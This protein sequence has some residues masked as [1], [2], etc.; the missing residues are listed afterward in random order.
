MPINKDVSTDGIRRQEERFSV[1][2]FYRGDA[3]RD[4]IVDLLGKV[5]REAIEVYNG[6]IE[7]VADAGTLKALRERGLTVVVENERSGAFVVGNQ[8][9]TPVAQAEIVRPAPMNL[10]VDKL[11]LPSPE[12]GST[13][14]RRSQ[15]KPPAGEGH[16]KKLEQLRDSA[17]VF[18]E[19]RDADAEAS[20]SFSADLQSAEPTKVYNVF[21]SIPVRPR[22]QA[23]LQKIGSGVCSY[24]A[25]NIY[26]MFLSAGEL[27][28]VKELPF[29]TGVRDY[30]I[31]ESV[32][33]DF[34]NVISLAKPKT[35]DGSL[36]SFELKAPDTFD[37]LLHRRQDRDRVIRAIEKAG[38]KVVE[39]GSDILRFTMQS[40]A[41]ALGALA[42]LPEVRKITPW[43]PPKLFADHARSVIGIEAINA[44]IGGQA[45][46]QYTGKDEI[47]GIFDS[48]IDDTH[49]DFAGQVKEK[50]SHN[51]C[52]VVDTIGHGTHVAGIVAGTGVASSGKIRGIAPGAKLVVVGMVGADKHLNIPPDIGELLVKAVD[53]GAK[54]INLSWG[55]KF[56]SAYEFGSLHLDRFVYDHQDV[57]VVVAA[58]NSG[59]VEDGRYVLYSIGTPATAKNALTVGASGNDRADIPNLWSYPPFSFP[60]PAGDLRMANADHVGALSSRGPTDYD[61]VKPDVCACGIYVLSARAGQ[62][63]MPFLEPDYTAYNNS[64]AFL[65]GTSMAAPV[66]SGAAAVLREYLRVAEKVANPSAALLKALLIASAHRLEQFTKDTGDPFMDVVGFPDFHQGF[67]R[68]DLASII[69]HPKAPAKRR[70][71]MDDVYNGTDRALHS[72]AEVGSKHVAARSYQLTVSANATDPLR[73]V[74]AWTDVPGKFLHNNLQLYVEGAG[75]VR[76]GNADLKFH[77]D[78]FAGDALARGNAPAVVKF[79]EVPFDKYNNVEQL[80]IEKPAAGDYRI[81]ILAQYTDP[82]SCAQGYALCV[83]GELDSVKLVEV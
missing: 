36:L 45:S 62:A 28:Q 41:G 71:L 30:G 16:E 56:G 9:G 66:V 70:I 47:V 38:G 21:V 26:R 22:Y 25:P 68:I 63:T 34:L 83:C 23:A 77:R 50:V 49:P 79:G 12:S 31:E 54:V 7:G 14:S 24:E 46:V 80:T 58:G 8:I 73:A 13:M 61:S 35:G 76:V 74:L 39:S 51:G 57:L 5:D 37:L 29:V 72:A 64:Y 27:E 43:R 2:V 18:R 55:D 3:Q 44:D 60:A 11:N 75:K 78:P 53:L 82:E 6:T 42:E 52:S 15:L 40:D 59:K 1:S 4:E 48:G 81:T 67:G 17:K 69:P 33:D 65:G 20:T 19:A 10:P 32:T